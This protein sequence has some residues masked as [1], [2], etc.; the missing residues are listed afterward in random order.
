MKDDHSALILLEEAYV[1]LCRV[2][3]YM[4]DINVIGKNIDRKKIAEFFVRA[5]KFAKDVSNYLTELENAQEDYEEGCPCIRE[6]C[7]TLCD[8]GCARYN[9]TYD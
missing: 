9:E 8:E 1:R 2:E 7:K 6:G 3:E 4:M 5:K